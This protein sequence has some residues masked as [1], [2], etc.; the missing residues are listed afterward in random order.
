[1]GI[2]R[3]SVI[4]A[5]VGLLGWGIYGLVE[6]HTALSEE[7]TILREKR[8][9][10]KEENILVE[11]DIEF[12]ENPENRVKLLKQQTNVVVPGEK[13]IIIVPSQA[14][15]SQDFPESEE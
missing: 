15:S 2:V 11:E 1:M 12:F 5:L 6:E 9:L 10:I 3:I 13:L 4:I 7:A 14:S 8:D